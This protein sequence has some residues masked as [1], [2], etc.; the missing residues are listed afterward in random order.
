[1]RY[2]GIDVGVHGALAVIDGGAADVLDMPVITY[3]QGKRQARVYDPVA[4]HKFLYQLGAADPEGRTGT[5]D[6]GLVVFERLH[7]MP[8]GSQASFSMGL[9][10]GMIEMALIA[11]GTRY[12]KV[13]PA[14]WK[15][16][17]GLLRAGKGKSRE[18]AQRY[19]PGVDLGKR[20]DEGRSEALLLALYAKRLHEGGKA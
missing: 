6:I 14:T 5:H 15:K 3:A 12:E 1:M 7:A 2:I 20:A 9:G 19:F 4:L 11:A 16:H 8:K 10:S 18:L 13:P 17:F